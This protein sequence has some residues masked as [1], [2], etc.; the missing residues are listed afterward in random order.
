[1][2]IKLVRTPHHG[3][4][5]RAELSETPDLP[6]PSSSDVRGWK[7]LPPTRR[8]LDLVNTGATLLISSTGE[9]TH[10]DSIE[11]L[12][13]RTGGLT[14]SPRALPYILFPG[15]VKS[16]TLDLFLD[17]RSPEARLPKDLERL[18]REALKR[19]DP[20]PFQRVIKAMQKPGKPAV[21]LD[22]YLT[23]LIFRL[24]R[25]PLALTDLAREMMGKEHSTNQGNSLEKSGDDERIKSLVKRLRGYCTI[26]ENCFG[27]RIKRRSPGRPRS[28][29]RRRR[30]P[31]A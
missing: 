20:K 11:S 7:R 26:L 24:N 31:G 22:G 12:V 14:H 28:A 6:E 15:D 18:F 9:V 3:A 8:F 16:S 27:F 30:R 2:K 29:G 23:K 5:S 4:Q 19:R 10:L 1:M 17:K 21:V 25:Q 13:Q